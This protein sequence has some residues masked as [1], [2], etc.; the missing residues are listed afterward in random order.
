MSKIGLLGSG[1]LRIKRTIS[2]LN[3]ITFG[4]GEPLWN[5]G[6][7][8]YYNTDDI[9]TFY[10]C[11]IGPEDTPYE[12]GF[13]GFRI[14]IPQEYPFKPPKVDFLTT[15][16][17]VR[18]NPNL[19]AC[20]KVC[21]SIL[22]TWNG[23]P[24]TSICTISSV[25][26]SLISLLQPIPIQNEP[27][28]D[29]IQKDSPKSI[30][31]NQAIEHENNRIAIID[32]IKNTS[33][34]N[35]EPFKNLMIQHFIRRYPHIKAKL[36]DNQ[37]LDSTEIKSHIYSC[38]RMKGKYKKML[39]NVEGL[40]SHY[41]GMDGS[42]PLYQKYTNI[43]QVDDECVE[44]SEIHT[45]TDDELEILGKKEYVKSTTVD[46]IEKNICSS[47]MECDNEIF[48]TVEYFDIKLKPSKKAS[49]CKEGTLYHLKSMDKSLT[50]KSYK[51]K[52]GRFR[53]KKIYQVHSP[54]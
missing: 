7:H 21:L 51:D 40:Y 44:Y 54:K 11:L 17:N 27:G 19:Y 31:Y 18:F 13:Y 2:D 37:E 26:L 50:F 4:K 20:G 36:I 32:M 30:S 42:M 9:T 3:E 8:V 6:I 53:W 24:W 5:D 52:A 14:M 38:M 28:W 1:G 48:E 41:M 43:P 34:Y 47:Q 10:A 35:L 23:P 12:D 45:Y 25:L 49:S 33:K 16:G 46:N 39:E 22:G 15:D 29:T